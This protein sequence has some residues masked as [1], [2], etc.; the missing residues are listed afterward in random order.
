MS[1]TTS[2]LTVQMLEWIGSSP[3]DYAEFI[4]AWGASLLR[5]ASREEA[6]LD[7]II[8]HDP[9][10]GKVSVTAKGSALL[11]RQKRSA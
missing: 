6:W 9:V 1:E 11:E 5:L 8:V 2:V 10:T 4:E 3:R 7:E